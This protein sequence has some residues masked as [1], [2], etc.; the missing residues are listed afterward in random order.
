MIDLFS[1][2]M[3]LLYAVFYGIT[4]KVADLFNEHEFKW[5]KHADV[6]FGS[7]WGIFGALLVISNMII[8]NVILAMIIAFLIRRRIDHINHAIAVIIIFIVFLVYV[9]FNPIIFVTFFFLLCLPAIFDLL[10]NQILPLL[11]L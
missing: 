1:L 9:A 4:M 5:F 7:L 10:Y 3:I 8:G 2:H 11:L 6:L